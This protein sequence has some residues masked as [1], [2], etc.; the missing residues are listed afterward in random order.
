MQVFPR[1]PSN[2]HWHEFLQHCRRVQELS[3]APY[4]ALPA[5]PL[6]SSLFDSMPEPHSV[7]FPNVRIARMHF[8]LIG[9]PFVGSSLVDLTIMVSWGRTSGVPRLVSVADVHGI[10]AT[11]CN[12]ETLRVEGSSPL[13]LIRREVMEFVCHLTNLKTLVLD[14]AAMSVTMFRK[15]S[16]LPNIE[17]VLVKECN[18]DDNGRVA[19]Y[20]EHASLW[21]P[22]DLPGPGCYPKL[23]H[24]AFETTRTVHVARIILQDHFPFRSLVSLW[25][26]F[27]S[28][29]V[30]LPSHVKR[31]LEELVLTCAVLEKLTLRFCGRRDGL[32]PMD[33]TTISML[34]WGDIEPFLSFPMLTEFAIDDTAPLFLTMDDIKSLAPRAQRFRK[35]WLNPY[36]AVGGPLG[37]K[38]SCL[39]LG[40]LVYL[41]SS[42]HALESLGLLVRVEESRDGEQDAYASLSPIPQFVRTVEFSIGRSYAPRFVFSRHSIVTALFLS[43]VFNNGSR[44]L[45]S[46]DYSWEA[47]GDWV[48]SDMRAH[49]EVLGYDRAFSPDLLL[50]WKSLWAMSMF[51]RTRRQAGY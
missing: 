23:R 44:L 10:A 50:G 26:K 12:L 31:L 3:I 15:A 34:C 18:R 11:L 41:A 47:A 48:C 33:E 46:S 27:V 25:I 21:S 38:K 37:M 19:M 28:G 4:G 6:C 35:L 51:I 9:L 32:P 24:F 39:G 30:I 43:R 49:A 20:S 45:T 8:D 2:K 7:V 5:S 42:C 16:L 17:R 29:P 36:P 1:P 22:S 40:A 14:P 13:A